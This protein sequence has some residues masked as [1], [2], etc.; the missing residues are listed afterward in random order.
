[1]TPILEVKNLSLTIAENPILKNLNFNLAQGKITG[2]VGESGSG[3]S[4]TALSIMRLLPEASETT[5]S[6]KYDSKELT[7]LS[8]ED[9][10]SLRGD[11]I[12]I[13]F[14]EPMTALNPLKTIGEQ[15]SEGIRLHRQ[16]SHDEAIAIAQDI[17]ERV[18]LP[19][20]RIS[21]DRFPHELSG[22]ER[23]RVVIAMACALKPKVLIADEPTTALDVVVQK[24]ILKLLEELARKNDVALLLISHDLGVVAE[25]ADEII[26]LRNGEIKEQGPAIKTL[27]EQKHPYT[28]QLSQASRHQPKKKVWEKFN[29]SVLVEVSDLV[30]TYPRPKLNLFSRPPPFIAVNSVS[31]T[32][33]ET[34]ILGLVGESGCGKSTL[35]RTLLG[36]NQPKGGS[37]SFKTTKPKEK[38]A[39]L[40][41]AIFQDPY[42]SFNPRH[43]A[44][45]LV[46][47]SLYPLDNLSENAKNDLVVEAMEA[48][49]LSSSDLNKYPHE[50][51]GGQRQRLAFS[52]AIACQP[53]LIVA[54]EP[55]SALDVSIRAQ[56]LDLIVEL[57][58][59]L[60][61]A[62]LFI[63]HDLSV[64]RN[65]CDEVMVMKSGEII[66][67]AKTKNIFEAPK[68]DY[69]KQ[70]I[71]A[72]PN[73]DAILKKRS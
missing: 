32:L 21:L 15:V 37:I 40:V 31:F 19:K 34:Q 69:T 8:E 43:T 71:E 62:W 14:Q 63:S 26:I 5:G 30:C 70:L 29:H 64:V 45:R 56:I 57:R 13:V 42:G 44:K 9:M 36:I 1:M 7:T 16:V 53:K 72:A 6:I 65:L 52:R 2:L 46:S 41:Q 4:L 60:Q 67:Y 22:G 28:K 3:K 17:L 49:G 54:D 73:L 12:A 61:V 20:E 18:G 25:M 39:G 10:C 66:E 23:Q 59:R 38:N 47:E 68:N 33:Y 55:V 24:Q 35:A 27:K 58:E 51:S 48:V 50:F 11:D